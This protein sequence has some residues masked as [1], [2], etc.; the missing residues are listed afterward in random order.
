VEIEVKNNT[1][2]PTAIHWHG[3]ELESYYDGVPGWTGSGEQITPAIAVGGSFVARMTPPRAGTYIYHTH[4][5]DRQQILNGL[6]GALIVLEPGQKFDP[7]HDKIFIWA[8]GKFAPFGFM[9]VVNG[10]PETYPVRLKTGTRYRLRLINMSDNLS[11]LHVRLLHDGAL[12]QWKIISRDGS[13][14]PTAQVK[15][16]AA[17]T[18][19]TVGET[20]DVEVQADAPGNDDLEF[21][22]T[23]FPM[24]STVPLVFAAGK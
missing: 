2:R 20:V 9:A 5:H 15:V 19:L 10:K 23:S 8:L 16:S 4:W 6:Y 13:D 11:D 14:L 17:D 3:M 24:P 21:R 22:M 18:G 1:Q 7:D 12:V